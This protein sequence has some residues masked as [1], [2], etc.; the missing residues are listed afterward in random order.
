M[1]RAM[2]RN[3]FAPPHSWT[4]L[5]QPEPSTIPLQS[6]PSKL[7]KCP[8]LLP[9]SDINAF[10]ISVKRLLAIFLQS[11][12]PDPHVQLHPDVHL[13]VLLPASDARATQLTASLEPDAASAPSFVLHVELRSQPS[14]VPRSGRLWVCSAVLL[15]R[16]SE[17]A[18][19]T[20]RQS[21]EWLVVPF[22]AAVGQDGRHPL[23]C[24]SLVTE[25]LRSALN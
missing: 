8:P 18:K 1:G 7:L 3:L 11:T 24:L 9:P 2:P 14:F 17:R 16:V 22:F 23:V 4:M 21:P 20:S 6:Q 10:K 12:L 19:K 5:L 15:A 25:L 13:T